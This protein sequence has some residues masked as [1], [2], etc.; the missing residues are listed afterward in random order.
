LSHSSPAVPP[1]NTLTV[2]PESLPDKLEESSLPDKVEESTEKHDSGIASASSAR[3]CPKCSKSFSR[4]AIYL[5]HRAV[6]RAVQHRQEIPHRQ[7]IT[8]CQEIARPEG[9]GR[10]HYLF[11]FCEQ[12]LDGRWRCK[13]C[14]CSMVHRYDLFKHIRA[15]HETVQKTETEASVEFGKQRPDGMWQCKLCKRCCN[16]RS[17]LNRHI[18]VM[19]A[20]RIC[21]KLAFPKLNDVVDFCVERPD[22]RW[23]CTLCKRLC[24]RRPDIYK[25]I[26]I[27]HKKTLLAKPNVSDAILST[28][29]GTISSSDAPEHVKKTFALT[30][31]VREKSLITKHLIKRCPCCSRVFMS[32]SGYK[33]H[34]GIC[35]KLALDRFVEEL[36]S[37]RVRCSL[38]N[39]TYSFRSTC[40]RHLRRKHLLSG[41]V[42]GIR[43]D[44]KGADVKMEETDAV[45]DS[46]T[47]SKSDENCGYDSALDN[48]TIKTEKSSTSA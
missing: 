44:C 23:E 27:K 11:N 32:P 33:Y 24:N 20:A 25:H 21:E 29:A 36:P 35:Q 12:V 26:Q 45:D 38:C 1:G 19:H 48:A 47:A 46:M 8:N 42:T 18:R 9:G 28:A 30:S 13:F 16:H 40:K 43:R 5:Q 41:E 34:M 6:C 37:G 14:K 3:S 4:I 17:S 39:M 7:G 10:Y 31:S 2:E 15:K 22:G